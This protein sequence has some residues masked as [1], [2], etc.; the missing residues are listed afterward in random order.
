MDDRSVFLLHVRNLRKPT[1]SVDWAI[2]AHVCPEGD[3]FRTGCPQLDA[4]AEIP[5]H[6]DLRSTAL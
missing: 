4:L 1:R 3:G 6:H 2:Y 5:V